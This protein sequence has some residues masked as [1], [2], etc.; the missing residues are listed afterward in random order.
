MPVTAGKAGESCRGS[1]VA[2]L[3][4]VFPWRHLLSLSAEHFIVTHNCSLMAVIGNSCISSLFLVTSVCLSF[5]GLGAVKMK[6]GLHV[7]P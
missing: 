3:A 2:V 4:L 1:L 5:A 7:V 6:Q